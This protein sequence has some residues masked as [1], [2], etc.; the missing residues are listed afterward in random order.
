MGY[1]KTIE[2]FEGIDHSEWILLKMIIKIYGVEKLIAVLSFIK[3]IGGVE[4]I[5]TIER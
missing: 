5:K 3:Q 2:C 4:N 1:M